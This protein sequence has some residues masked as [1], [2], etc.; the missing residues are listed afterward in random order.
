[1]A[2]LPSNQMGKRRRKSDSDDDVEFLGSKRC[3]TVNN[4]TSPLCAAC[5]TLDIDFSFDKA[6]EYYRKKKISS[7]NLSSIH[8][9]YD[10]RYF[11]NDAF[12]VHQF[13]NQLSSPSKCSLCDFFRSVRVQPDAHERYKLLAFP[14]SDAWLFHGAR[15]KEAQRQEDWLDL[16]TRHDTVFMA[17]VPDLESIP[18]TAHDITWL[19][20][21]IPAVGAIFRQPAGESRDNRDQDLLGA[22]ELPLKFDLARVRAWLDVCRREHGDACKQ[23]ASYEPVTRGFRLINCSKDP[24]EVEEKPWGTPYAALSYVWGSTPAD[25]GMWP[26]TVMDAVEVARKLDSTYLWVD[27]SCIN[28]SDTDEQGYLISRMTTIYEAAE[29]TIVAAAGDGASHGLPGVR[30]TPRR[31][32]PKYYT[33]SGSL[34]LSILPDPRREVMKSQ[35]WTRGWTYQEGVLSNRRIVFTDHQIY[36]ECRSMASHESADVT[37]FHTTASHKD[38][39][40]YL[41]ADFM[42]TG[43]FKGGAFSGGS[44]AHQDDSIVENDE[45]YRLD[46]GF[47]VVQEITVRAQLRGL[48]DHMREFTKRNLKQDSD[49]LSAFQGVVGM[50]EQTESLCLFQGIPLWTGDIAGSAAGAQITFALSVSSWYHRA[51][52]DHVMYISEACRRRTHLPSWTWAGWEGTISWRLPPDREHCAY[53]SDLIKATSPSIV[54]AANIYLSHPGSQ[55]R[56]RLLDR[57]SALRLSSEM[58]STIEIRDPYLLTAFDRI[59]D[60]DRKWKWGRRVGRPGRQEIVSYSSDKDMEWYRM[61]HK[62]GR[63]AFTGMSVAITQQQWTSKHV[64]GEFVSV[65]MFAGRFCVTEHGA[66][67]FLTLRKVPE[68]SPTLWERVGILSLTLPYLDKAGCRDVSG[69]FA[70]IPARRQ[71]SGSIVIR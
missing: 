58:L 52:P 4:P 17:V 20:Y 1:M 44:S 68:A 19:D 28:Q 8:E 32:Q 18:S 67:R 21:E 65:L 47:P 62:K 43:I 69:L 61:G 23:R 66:A 10:R 26:A 59:K 22:R 15:L 33:D 12:L 55:S 14:S 37:L 11:Y 49:S 64:S 48:A 40:N 45:E 54:W 27:R 71:T 50:Y 30:S 51:G 16:R 7:T 13:G 42:L 25:P 38:D 56:V 2:A 9:A 36:W 29:F 53:M 70:W 41:L 5:Q 35:Y 3:R 60:V 57:S 34:V 39:P 6:Y 31:P 24:P 46:Y 63:L